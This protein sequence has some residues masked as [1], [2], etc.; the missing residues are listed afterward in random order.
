MEAGQAPT[1]GRL[2]RKVKALP[3]TDEVR[4]VTTALLAELVVI[5]GVTGPEINV[6]VP[7]VFGL[8]VRLI[9]DL[10]HKAVAAPALAAT[11]T[12]MVMSLVFAAQPGPLKVVHLKLYVPCVRLLIVE[13][14]ETALENVGVADPGGPVITCQ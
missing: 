6:H 7:E 10:S 3:A 4:P 9:V 14:G 13:V 8:P 12:S 5:V 1:T 11:V 2:Y